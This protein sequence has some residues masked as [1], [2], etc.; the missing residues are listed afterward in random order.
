MMIEMRIALY[1]ISNSR[2]DFLRRYAKM[3][4]ANNTSREDIDRAS[5]WH[6]AWT[7]QAKKESRK[8]IKQKREQWKTR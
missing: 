5:E 1:N 4:G 8:L 7:I 6:K 2:R 3:K